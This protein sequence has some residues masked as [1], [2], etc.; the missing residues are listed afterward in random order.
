MSAIQN[1]V[2]DANARTMQRDEKAGRNNKPPELRLKNISPTGLLSFKFTKKMSFPDNLMSLLHKEQQRN[3]EEDGEE[4]EVDQSL[5]IELVYF[6]GVEDKI[7]SEINFVWEIASL[8]SLGIDIKITF[9][10]P[11]EV[12]QDIEPD[13]ALVTINGFDRFEDESGK[14]LQ[15]S[16]IKKIEI[17]A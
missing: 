11:L 7:N 6:A 14:K 2:S 15:K 16:I 3:L 8:T 10:N 17:P 5:K 13:F 1:L 12:S 9:E 4:I